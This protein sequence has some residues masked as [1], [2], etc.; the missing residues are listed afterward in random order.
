MPS[1]T[2]GLVAWPWR[3]ASSRSRAPAASG[4]TLGAAA[5]ARP[6][7]R[8]TGAAHVRSQGRERWRAWRTHPSSSTGGANE[9]VGLMMLTPTGG[10]TSACSTTWYG[11]RAE[12]DEHDV[13]GVVRGD[14]RHGQ[15][16]V[17]DRLGGPGDVGALAHRVPLSPFPLRSKRS[18]LELCARATCQVDQIRAWPMWWALPSLTSRTA[19]RD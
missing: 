18:T 7:A 13:G 16:D 19:G 14:A 12:A 15:V 2:S 6:M 17:L 4:L 1:G 5:D 11:A 9:K 3:W 8:S 10:C